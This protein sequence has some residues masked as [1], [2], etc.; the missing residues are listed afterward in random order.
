MPLPLFLRLSLPSKTGRIRRGRLLTLAILACTALSG[1]R[2]A[3]DFSAL[4]QL[5]QGAVAGS[6]VPQAVP[7]F[8][9]LLWQNGLPIYHQSFGRWTQGTAA[10][11]DSAT[12]TISGALVMALTETQPNFQLDTKLSSLLPSFMDNADKRD[13][14]VRQAFSH[15]SGLPGPTAGS[16]ILGADNITLQQAA[17]LVARLPMENGP[18][19]SS[20]SYGG[21]SMHAAGAAAE[22][23]G[24]LPYATLMQQRVLDPLG[25]ASTRFVLP[26]PG[27]QNPRVAGGLESTASDMASFMDM[28]LA[29]GVRR[30]TGQRV[31]AASS[32][33]TMLTRQTTDDQTL[34]SS[35]T[36]DSL[37][38]I[39]V[40][41]DQLETTGAE[42]VDALAAGARGFHAWIDHDL[43][44]VF[45]F[46]TDR[47]SFE[48]IESLSAQMH[49]T[50]V[51]T[52]AI[53]EP[54][55]LL[56]WALGS[57]LLAWRLRRVAGTR[58]SPM[59]L[60]SGG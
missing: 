44:L 18:A 9:L 26:S 17:G 41:L 45:V 15:T 37:Y 34:A 58:Q 36:E 57:G 16:A 22:V 6:N 48:N 1:A 53:P 55:P 14:T 10:N 5:A 35:P 23:A 20:F 19:G 51:N 13:I 30:S 60:D 40:W 8:E 32:V 24:G 52:L 21:V 46:A 3:T 43:D 31:L 38:G 29:D 47:T 59:A 54:Q 56:M 42:P 33:A 50:I 49:A 25:M 4:T 12:K 27:S 28:L 11:M 2:A 7:G 39:G